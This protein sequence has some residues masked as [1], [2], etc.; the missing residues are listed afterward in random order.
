MEAAR[1]KRG[2]Y[3]D[4]IAYKLYFCAYTENQFEPLIMKA[5]Y[6]LAEQLKPCIWE[7][8]G[9]QASKS[10]MSLYLPGRG[11]AFSGGAY[12]EETWDRAAAVWQREQMEAN[13]GPG[14]IVFGEIASSGKLCARRYLRPATAWAKQMKDPLFY[15]DKNIDEQQAKLEFE[16]CRADALKL[17]RCPSDYLEE[18]QQHKRH[19][20]SNH[21]DLLYGSSNVYRNG[22]DSPTIEAV[23]DRPPEEIRAAKYRHLLS[24]RVPRYLFHGEMK[25]FPYQQAWIEEVTKLCERFP[26]STAS[27]RMDATR[28]SFEEFAVEPMF[29]KRDKIY[30][31]QKIAGYV[32]GMWLTEAQLKLLGGIAAIEKQE[33]FYRV[34]SL[35]SG[36]VFLQLTEHVNYVPKD[37]NDRL[38]HYL[39]PHLVPKGITVTDFFSVSYRMSF[40]EA[41]VQFGPCD[42]ILGGITIQ[43]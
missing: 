41:D 36:G 14:F 26:Y 29:S 19:L 25:S 37:L 8:A 12:S 4:P 22:E 32:W 42:P 11:Y 20:K 34:T 13:L 17:F 23:A 21:L 40:E 24:F 39:K 2:S 9:E 28:N 30:M 18:V 38:Y 31:A 43:N 3:F 1:I 6:K 33:L 15:I 10:D 35:K 5:F 27:M 7:M 16:R